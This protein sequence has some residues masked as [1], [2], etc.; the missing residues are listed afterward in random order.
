VVVASRLEQDGRYRVV[1]SPPV[2]MDHY[3][4]REDELRLNAEKVLA[5]AEP[6]I[7]QAPGQWLIFQPVWPG[8]T[9]FAPT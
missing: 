3:A 1:A 8:V 7:R 9:G 4:K 2:E 6:F 5:L